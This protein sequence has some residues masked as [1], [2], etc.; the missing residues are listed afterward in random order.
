[1]FKKIVVNISTL[2]SPFV[3][4]L[5]SEE[6]THR[7][8]RQ[9]TLDYQRSMAKMLFDDVVRSKPST[10]PYVTMPTSEEVKVPEKG[11]GD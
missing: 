6:L 2:L 8:S 10:Y 9:V 7:L 3:V 5:S 4:L 11:E 1:M